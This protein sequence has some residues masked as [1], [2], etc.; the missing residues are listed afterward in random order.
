MELR[1]REYNKLDNETKTQ[2]HP[3]RSE[4]KISPNGDKNPFL[5]DHNTQRLYTWAYKTLPPP[6]S[7]FANSYCRCAVTER[8]LMRKFSSKPVYFSSS[9]TRWELQNGAT[10]L[11]KQRHTMSF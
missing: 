7:K 8:Q 5:D 4:G 3:P 6:K 1:A 9:A 10:T 2:I 11:P